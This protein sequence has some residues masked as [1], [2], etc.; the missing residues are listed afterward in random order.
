[1]MKVLARPTN[2][3]E[4]FCGQ[5]KGGKAK[6]WH[7]KKFSLVCRPVTNLLKHH[8]RRRV[9]WEW[10]QF[11]DYVQHIFLGRAK[12]FVPLVTG[13]CCFAWDFLDS[14]GPTTSHLLSFVSTWYN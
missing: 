14:T 5:R 8:G 11:L 3:A 4:Q 9:F 6:C 7:F 2:N 1:M 10:P 12:N 13:A